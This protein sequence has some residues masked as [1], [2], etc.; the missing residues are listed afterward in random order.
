M[1]LNTPRWW[2]SRDRRHAP[3]TR[4][5]LKPASWLWAGVTARRIAR[6][7]PVSDVVAEEGLTVVLVTHDAR[8]AAYADR[9]VVLVSGAAA[10]EEFFRAPEEDLDQAAAYPFMTPVFG[11]GVVFDASPEERSK[12]IHNAALEGPHMKQH[13]VTIPNEVERIIAD[14]G[15]EGEID[16]LD[17]FADRLKVQQREAGV[18]HDLIDAVFALPGQDD[19]LMVVRRVE[20]LGT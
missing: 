9:E 12:A 8:I 2:Y 16:L 4:M 3:M 15:D 19:L 10:N 1:K 7:T 18:R 6:A 20:A 13:A 17:F 11:E 14:W 5:M